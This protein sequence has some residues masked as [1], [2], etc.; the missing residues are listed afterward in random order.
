[1]RRGPRISVGSDRTKLLCAVCT[2]AAIVGAVGSVCWCADRLAD[3]KA[4]SQHAGADASK[5]TALAATPPHEQT[6]KTTPQRLRKG[7][8][9]DNE[10]G[11]FE[12]AGDRVAFVPAG[13]NARFVVLENLNLERIARALGED[14]DARQWSVSGSITEYRGGNY[15]LV[16]RAILKSRTRPGA[17]RP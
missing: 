6:E 3:A 5:S 12:T 2:T 14:P 13:G 10:L 8:S 7:A 17:P 16:T 4:A 15:L 1:M 11:Q 9:L